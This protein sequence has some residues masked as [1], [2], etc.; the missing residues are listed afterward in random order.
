MFFVFL[1]KS[2]HFEFSNFRGEY[3]FAYISLAVRDASISLKFLAFRWAA[4]LCL[5]FTIFFSFEK[6]NHFEFLAKT[7]N[8]FYPLN[9][10]RLSQ[11]IQICFATNSIFGSRGLQA[12][13]LLRYEIR[14]C[15]TL[16]LTYYCL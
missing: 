8:C 10:A 13:N 6:Y 3:K 1:K 7:Q 4:I 9:S 15:T 12:A 5:N 16:Y 11:F 14:P 2:S